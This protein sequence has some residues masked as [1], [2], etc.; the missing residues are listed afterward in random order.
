M[1]SSNRDKVGRD[2]VSLSTPIF[3][4]RS[5]IFWRSLAA[6]CISSLLY[7]LLISSISHATI[8]DENISVSTGQVYCGLVTGLA[9][10]SL[11]TIFLPVSGAHLNPCITLAS[12]LTSQI[13]P[14]RAVGHV[15]A[16]CGGAVAGASVVL[17]LHGPVD[18][19]HAISTSS[20]GLEF[21]LTFMVALVY[22][23]VTDIS[24]QAQHNPALPIGLSY[25]AALTAYRGAVNPALALGQAFVANKFDMHWIFWAGPL[26]GGACAA[27]IYLFLVMAHWPQNRTSQV[28][29]QKDENEA[30][31]EDHNL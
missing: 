9:I 29:P 2:N 14:A 3:F 24:N 23:R 17:G 21:L 8:S 22:L 15:L 30:D 13:T 20:F 27:L 26:I 18:H 10:I 19:F 28:Y 7:V 16:Q 12:C 4:Y 5:I 31:T 25:M 6:E 11:T 1:G